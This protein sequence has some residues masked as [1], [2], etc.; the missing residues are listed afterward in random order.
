MGA[1]VGLVGLL[2]L[3]WT[4]PPGCAVG[5]CDGFRHLE[6]GR[7]FFRYGGLYV[8]FTCNPGFKLHGHRTSS[9]LSGRWIR[10][11]PV[12][13]ASGCPDPGQ[14]QHGSSTVTQGGSF[15]AFA[16]HGGY[17]LYGPQLLYCQGGI[18]NTTRPVCKES[19]IMSSDKHKYL[20][21]LVLGIEHNA[22]LP[23][24]A[25]DL[26][27]FWYN[28]DANTPLKDTLPKT[29]LQ[30]KELLR[31]S[32]PKPILEEHVL[33]E[34][35]PERDHSKKHWPSQTSEA[36][37]EYKDAYKEPVD[38]GAFISKPEEFLTSS[39]SPTPEANFLTAS[40]PESKPSS[41][42]PVAGIHED[43]G[44]QTEGIPAH[45]VGSNLL[46]A[47]RPDPE[48]PN[49]ETIPLNSGPV[50]SPA[51]SEMS[52]PGAD[53]YRELTLESSLE[54]YDSSTGS[55]LQDQ[56]FTL[57]VSTFLATH[58]LETSKTWATPTSMIQA[59]F[60]GFSSTN[61]PLHQASSLQT[62]V[63][64][65]TAL[66]GDIS[67]SQ[68]APESRATS[69]DAASSGLGKLISQYFMKKKSTEMDDDDSEELRSGSA[70]GFVK[71][72]SEI[73]TS[74]NTKEG[75]MSG[76]PG[77]NSAMSPDPA[78]A[79]APTD[80]LFKDSSDLHSL[81]YLKPTVYKE[82]WGE[83][84][85]FSISARLGEDGTWQG[86]LLA[87][88]QEGLTLP[89][90]VTQ[91]PSAAPYLGTDWPSSEPA[92]ASNR[93]PPK[94]GTLPPY[95]VSEG[96][97]W[98]S[99]SRDQFVTGTQE[100][101]ATGSLVESTSS[102]IGWPRTVTSPT[103]RAGQ[104]GNAS[105]AIGENLLPVTANALPGP[106]TG[107]PHAL[108]VAGQLWVR[109]RRPTCPYPPLPAHGTFYFRTVANPTP[110]QYK[111]FVQYACYPG[112]TLANGD[113]YS[114]CLQGGK[115]SG[116]TPVCIEETPCLISNGG[117]SQ[118]CDIDPQ[119]QARCRCRQG[120]QLLEDARTC[121]AT[122]F[123]SNRDTKHPEVPSCM[124]ANICSSAWLWYPSDDLLGY[125]YTEL[126]HCCS[127]DTSNGMYV[128][129]YPLY[130]K[131]ICLSI[132]DKDE[133]AEETH[134][135]QQICINTFGSFECHCGPGYLLVSD[136]TTCS[137]RDECA[138]SNGG[139][140]HHCANSAGSFRCF[141]HPGFQLANDL[142]TCQ[143]IDEC[144]LPVG[145]A[146]CLF[147]CVNTP[148]S[149]RCYCP[150]GYQLGSVDGHCQDIDECAKNGGRGLCAM[151][152]HN[153][154]GSFRCSCAYGYQL[155]GDGR[156][157]VAECPAGYRKQLDGATTVGGPGTHC[158]DVNE[159]ES[160]N[161]GC[162]HT[163]INYRGGYNC[164]CPEFYRLSPFSKKWCQPTH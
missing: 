40:Y 25:K 13:V 39:A 10:D 164:A 142:V 104:E 101:S 144:E 38:Y 73:S 64:F 88:T 93:I 132:S 53:R 124:V 125:T 134:S 71:S 18:W 52:V 51:P 41:T 102:T 158:V 95:P 133:C 21:L 19:D 138:V 136:G 126:L 5:T 155:A 137:D 157:C 152:C 34:I 59:G 1:L 27:A 146:T 65:L 14:P 49:T 78:M 72:P 79:L 85:R 17:R 128:C 29:G 35:P 160:E 162:S 113:V 28:N 156:S 43:I 111:H 90:E 67:T 12:C 131:P 129:S 16:C 120:F 32:H 127:L 57:E 87:R 31:N 107:S 37:V 70:K 139:C 98:F 61:P 6:N 112:Y 77:V 96:P 8:T 50:T 154:P 106:M 130:V 123:Q 84:S 76:Q 11:P 60:L 140:T 63:T 159:C 62:R 74:V 83:S 89:G 122:D 68:S 143:D 58:Y 80:S 55:E 110:Q 47:R 54:L 121:R 75:K 26:S 33:K 163:C 99:D 86:I 118:F 105:S 148:G 135:C 56:N 100:D 114:Y 69:M 15:A 117:C 150:E 108:K 48:A 7:T 147:G 23:L 22:N 45:T 66:M 81:L 116:V 145:V 9:C 161:G 36:G 151:A 44:S 3:S 92:D 115:W 141:C 97:K 149:Y 20:D 2:A 94:T 30:D 82:D 42:L 103:S 4:L 46:V 153:M 24:S 119:N 91:E 109:R